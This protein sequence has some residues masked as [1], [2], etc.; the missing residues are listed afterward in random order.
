MISNLPVSPGDVMSCLICVYSPTEAGV[1]M[2]NVTTGVGTSFIKTAPDNVQLEGN[3][4]EWVLENP[5][6]G[7]LGPLAKYGQVYF[8]YCMALTRDGAVIE[9]GQT[10]YSLEMHDVNG[11]NISTAYSVGDRTIT[12]Q[13]TEPP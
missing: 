4:V 9:G 5:V 1:Y 3:S 12:T 2:R 6:S 11:E 10:R 13:Y 7:W 8:D